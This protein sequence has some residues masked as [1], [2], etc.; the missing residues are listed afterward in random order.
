MKIL[1]CA[2]FLVLA[3][4]I[5]GCGGS[6]SNKGSG[7]ENDAAASMND[8]AI[9]VNDAAPPSMNDAS[10]SP[11]GGHGS[12]ESSAALFGARFASNDLLAAKFDLSDAINTAALQPI[13]ASPYAVGPHPQAVVADPT[14]KFLFVVNDGDGGQGSVTA[15]T[16]GADRTLTMV[17][18]SPFNV[19]GRPQAAAVDP[20]GSA[21]YVLNEAQLADEDGITAFSIDTATGALAPLGAVVDLSGTPYAITIETSGHFAYVATLQEGVYPIAIGATGVGTVGAAVPV[22]MSP[23]GIA[24]DSAGKFLYVANAS[25]KNVSAFTID[26][27]SGTLTPVAGSPFN[28]V[29]NPEPIVV[30]PSGKFLFVSGTSGTSSF[31]IDGASGVLSPTP[32][33]P[34]NY[35]AVTGGLAVEKARNLLYVGSNDGSIV[36]LS[37]DAA[38]GALTYVARANT[39]VGLSDLITVD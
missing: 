38:T 25:S 8:A 32:S 29:T 13:G 22:G 26:S 36:A 5:V 21:I 23:R 33:S 4:G 35:S 18:G 19:R 34:S 39:D 30:S 10:D 15:F 6:S 31:A 3:L 9:P 24:T 12:L 20:G 2:S 17:A 7:G 37:F 1:I 11:D 27:T 28:C 16:I 14:G